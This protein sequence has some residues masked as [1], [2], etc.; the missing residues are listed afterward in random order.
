MRMLL[1]YMKKLFFTGNY[2]EASG[3]SEIPGE[4]PTMTSLTML[5]KMIIP[6]TVSAVG[7]L[8]VYFLY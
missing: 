7:G 5:R 4:H 1:D 6:Q 3:F 2:R 8:A